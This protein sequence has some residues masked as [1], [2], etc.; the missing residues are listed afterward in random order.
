[1]IPKLKALIVEY[2][3]HYDLE[4]IKEA[5][6]Y[7]RKDLLYLAEQERYDYNIINA[8]KRSKEIEQSRTVQ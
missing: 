5:R 6:N 8:G 3:I 4:S 1:M 2:Q 7:V